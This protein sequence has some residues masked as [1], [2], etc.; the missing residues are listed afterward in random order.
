M[1]FGK[2]SWDDTEPTDDGGGGDGQRYAPRR[3]WIPKPAE[4]GKQFTKR[5]MFIDSTPF[6]F[7]EH[8]LFKITN[9]TKD[10]C[11]CLEK[12]GLDERGCPVC[13]KDLWAYYIG[14]FSVINMG[15][16][17]LNGSDLTLEGWT[18][19]KNDK[20][21]Q[22][23][24]EALGAK[25]GGKDKPGM[26]QEWK[27]Q[28][29]RRGGDIVGCVFDLTRSGKLVETTG[30]RVEFIERV[31]PEKWEEYFKALGSDETEND[32]ILEPIDYMEEFKQHSYDALQS[33]CGTAPKPAGGGSGPRSEGA[34]YG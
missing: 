15:D 29:D 16:V 3:F 17:R 20:L 19:P 4:D 27:R 24:R 6:C 13:D 18:N 11:I 2:Q 25:R 12:N 21:F 7:F 26:L 1:G 33:L 14:Y 10:R 30:D 22:F 32:L 31:P 34:D 9:S 23:G 28:I 8:S 5:V